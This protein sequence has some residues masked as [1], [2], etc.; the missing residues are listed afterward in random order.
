MQNRVLVIGGGVAGMSSAL[1]VAANGYEVFL[2][3]KKASLGGR[4]INYCCKATDKC[5]KCSA[6]LVPQAKMQLEKNTGVIVYESSEVTGISGQAGDFKIRVKTPK[7]DVELEAGAIIIATGFEPFDIANKRKEYGYSINPNVVTGLEFEQALKENGSLMAA[8]GPVKN[9]GF[10]QCVGSRDLS[11]DRSG[12]CSKVCCMYATKLAKLIRAELPEAEIS[13]FYMDLQTF[14]RGFDQF[15]LEAK[16]DSKI[17]F[18]RGIPSKIYS[19]PYDRL[20]VKYANSLTGE[21]VEDMFDLIVL[22][23]AIT[24]GVDN[25]KIA[26]IVNVDTDSCG[27]FKAHESEPIF[28]KKDGVFVAGT[29]QSPKDILQSMVQAKA[30]ASAAIALLSK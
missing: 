6:C 3:E 29:C 21:A 23:T 1:E 17:Q 11:F 14:G 25:D 16:T 27:F 18:I 20:T 10:I 9:V 19:F 4:A 26:S 15:V 30:A 28:T 5:N 24:P 22:S 12:Y 7:G 13:I 8:Y 2:V